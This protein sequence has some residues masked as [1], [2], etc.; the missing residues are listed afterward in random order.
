MPQATVLIL[1]GT[2][3]AREL[4]G[5]LVGDN[6]TVVTSYAGRTTDPRKPP[7]ETRSGGFGGAAGLRDWLA[8]R[9]PAILVD[10]THPF[11][12]T[13]SAHAAA[14][15]G[16][17]R[18]RLA[19]PGWTEAPGDRWLRVASLDRAADLLPVTGHRA[20]ITTG[21]Q[22]IATFTT[23]PACAG[24]PLLLV[25]CVEPPEDDD[26]PGNVHLVLDRG[27]FTLDHERDLLEAHEIDVVVA[28]DS[29]GGA[30]RAKLDAARERGIPVIL[31]DRPRTVAMPT[32][33][34]PTEAAAWV[35]ELVSG[36]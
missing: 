27:P 16:V 18:L 19:R 2:T 7:G 6:L 29:G 33:P 31:V 17:P 30:T 3:E 36:P 35:R 13:V 10:A 15:H 11:A 14:V 20:L 4:A 8:A 1:G 26:L 24:L 21:R 9:R 25:R 34:T 5:L 22:R 28:K 23:H 32:V 12:E